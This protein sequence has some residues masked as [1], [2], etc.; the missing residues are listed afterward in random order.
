MAVK[1]LPWPVTGTLPVYGERARVLRLCAALLADRD[2]GQLQR[3]S[4]PVKFPVAVDVDK[5]DKRVR[6][7]RA[8]ERPVLL[9]ARVALQGLPVGKRSPASRMS[10]RPVERTE[11]HR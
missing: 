6:A 1:A 4:G 3:D 11:E 2:L 9:R 5:T 8:R 7:Q 10:A